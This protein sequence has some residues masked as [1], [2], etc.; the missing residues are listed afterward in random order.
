MKQALIDWLKANAAK[1]IEALVIAGALI[2]AGRMWLQE[3]DA[4]LNAD[5]HVQQAEDSISKL[6][7]EQDHVEKNTQTKVVI[8]RDKLAEVDTPAKAIVAIPEQ[9]PELK[10]E[11][12][13]DA[14]D[15]V[16][17]KA[18]PLFKDL[19]KGQQ[20]A[21]ELE[22]CQQSL[23]LQ[24]AIDVE[25]VQEVKAEGKKP[26]FFKRLG[27]AAKVT[28]CAGIGGGAGGAIQGGKGAAI[29]AAVGALVCQAF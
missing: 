29:G 3:H 14:P 10:A 13:P 19:N 5:L 17:V 4:R 20:C 28:T 25:R 11:P 23:A 15:M 9:A 2:F 27:H 8:L 7:V 1:H 16:A 21:V 18:V 12:L 26:G 22:G 24:K 6:L